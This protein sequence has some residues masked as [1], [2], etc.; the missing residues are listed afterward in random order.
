MDTAPATPFPIVSE[1]EDDEMETDE[2]ADLLAS[3]SKD[4]DSEDS[5]DGFQHV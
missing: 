4:G 2:E 5:D 3:P 1:D